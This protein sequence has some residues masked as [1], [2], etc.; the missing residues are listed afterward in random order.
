MNKTKEIKNLDL[1]WLSNSKSTN[2]KTISIN[3]SSC[4]NPF[5][6]SKEFTNEDVYV[7]FIT[8]F[9]PYEGKYFHLGFINEFFDLKS[10]CMC[11]Q[12]KNAFYLNT[13]GE[14]FYEGNVI[15]GL[16]SNQPKFDL[17]NTKIGIKIYFSKKEFSFILSNQHEAG[18][19]KI[20]SGSKFSLIFGICLES[21]G[22]IIINK[23]HY[24]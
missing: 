20:T 2:P 13:F 7:E 6:T 23:S 4:Y 9:V 14:I 16:F 15:S 21:R 3:N 18:P 22:K 12:P 24:L 17:W 10:D 1:F 5:I 11:S 8:D 19:F